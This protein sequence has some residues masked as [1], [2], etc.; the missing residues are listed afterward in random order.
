MKQHPYNTLSNLCHYHTYLLDNKF[1]NVLNFNIFQ[2]F[3]PFLFCFL[4]LSTIVPPL[5]HKLLT[6]SFVYLVTN[7]YLKHLHC[8]LPQVHLSVSHSPSFLSLSLI[9]L[10]KILNGPFLLFQLFSS[11]FN[12][13]ICI[14]PLL[15]PLHTNAEGQVCSLPATLVL[16]VFII[17]AHFCNWPCIYLSHYTL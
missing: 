9:T 2:S 4:Y 13:Q 12:L 17:T 7:V 14:Y 5:V 6:I 1:I 11:N 16:G 3:L 8:L 15:P 10:F